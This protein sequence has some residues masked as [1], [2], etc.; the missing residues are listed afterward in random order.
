M[1]GE[2]VMAAYISTTVMRHKDKRGTAS[3]QATYRTYFGRKDGKYNEY[4]ND[5]DAILISEGYED[6]IV[7]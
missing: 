2:V 3:G 4:K 5:V 1:K 7:E 6:C